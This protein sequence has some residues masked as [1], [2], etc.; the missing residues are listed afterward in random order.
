MYRRTRNK[1]FPIRSNTLT[2]IR[3]TNVHKVE[4]ITNKKHFK[5]T[6][7]SPSEFDEKS[8]FAFGS[9]RVCRNPYDFDVFFVKFFPSQKQCGTMLKSDVLRERKRGGGKEIEFIS[10][11]L[12]M[13]V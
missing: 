8:F 6:K 10:F 1:N 3:H 9:L 5:C 7:F 11:I 4:E 12:R 13:L 2:Y